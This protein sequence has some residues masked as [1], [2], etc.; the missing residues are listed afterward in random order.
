MLNF[1]KVSGNSKN[2]HQNSKSLAN[3]SKRLASA[4][5]CNNY[6]LAILAGLATFPEQKNEYVCP[7]DAQ[8]QN[9]YQVNA[10]IAVRLIKL[11]F[12]NQ[13]PH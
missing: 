3:I 7:A 1:A 10:N 6:T 8:K 13:K 12:K 5:H 4:T 2:N 9:A 11:L